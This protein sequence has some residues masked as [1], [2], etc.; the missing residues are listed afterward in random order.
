MHESTACLHAGSTSLR[1]PGANAKAAPCLVPRL[2]EPARLACGPAFVSLRMLR[3]RFASPCLSPGRLRRPGF[4][5]RAACDVSPWRIGALPPRSAAVS[6][7]ILF[8]I[9]EKL[10]I[11]GIRFAILCYSR[12]AVSPSM[13]TVVERCHSD[14]V[15]PAS[16][17]QN[18]EESLCRTDRNLI[19]RPG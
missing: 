2:R 12:N 13:F 9:P 1:L 4:C 14:G 7:G 16:A 6:S 11:R 17:R 18:D 19:F 8:V 3:S 10:G 5:R 15:L